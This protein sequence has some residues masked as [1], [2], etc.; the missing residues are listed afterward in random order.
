MDITPVSLATL[1]LAD[2]LADPARTRA[3]VVHAVDPWV[4]P[5]SA[6][7]T[8]GQARLMR[9]TVAR[10]IRARATTI[11][12]M[13]VRLAPLRSP[14]ELEVKA[15]DPRKLIPRVAQR[16]KADLILVGSMSR[17]SIF[18]LFIGSVAE[19]VLERARTDVVIVRQPPG[20]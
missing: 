11:R 6:D 13:V 15:C 17:P 1:R 18:R 4:E 19:G 2:R 14:W 8:P 20:R 3:I 5:P 12:H 7:L 10:A 9:A 16:R